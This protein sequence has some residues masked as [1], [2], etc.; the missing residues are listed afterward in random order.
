MANTLYPGQIDQLMKEAGTAVQPQQ[1]QDAPAGVAPAEAHEVVQQAG[2]DPSQLQKPEGMPQE[3]WDLVKGDMDMARRNT[4]GQT[5]KAGLQGGLDAASFGL[6]GPAEDAL[7]IT[8]AEGR[9]QNAEDHGV[10][11]AVGQAGGLLTSLFA[12]P[13]GVANIAEHAGVAGAATVGLGEAA[14]T[15]T[16]LARANAAFKAGKGTQEAVAAAQ[17][18]YSAVPNL[19]RIGSKATQLAIENVVIQAGDENAKMFMETTP[20]GKQAVADAALAH[21]GLAAALGGTLGAGGQAIGTGVKSLWDATKSEATGGVLKA[22]ADKLGGVPSAGTQ[23]RED[24]K[25]TA[26]IGADELSPSTNAMMSDNAAVRDTAAKMRDSPS[27]A[28]IAMKQALVEDGEM[29]SRKASEALGKSPEDL[30]NLSNVSENKT[31][32][33]AREMIDK[34]IRDQYAPLKTSYEK[35]S[36]Q[37]AEAPLQEDMRAYL[38]DSI[39]QT[40]QDG[41]SLNSP[42]GKLVQRVLTEIPGIT[43]LKQL[44]NKARGIAKETSGANNSELWDIGRRIK[45]A[46]NEVQEAALQMHVSNEAPELLEELKNTSGA[47]R[48]LKSDIT[49]INGRLGVKQAEVGPGTFLKNLKDMDPEDILRRLDPSHRADILTELGAKHPELATLIKDYHLS[50]VLRD[51]TY[52]NGKETL[53]NIPKLINKLSAKSMTP[54][55]RDAIVPEAAMDKLQALYSLQKR[56]PEKVGKSGTPEGLMGLV[57]QMTGSVVAFMT[58]MM[59]HGPITSGIM[60]GLT[61][62]L[63]S[64]A[65]DAVRYAML[66]FLGTDAPVNAAGFRAMAGVM[67]SALR[68]QELASDGVK[69]LFKPGVQVLPDVIMPNKHD[70]EK[71]QKHLDAALQNPSA[72]VQGSAGSPASHYMPDE[73]AAMG[74]TMNKVANYM[75]TLKPNVSPTG[76][77]DPARKPS[78]IEK[79]NYNRALEIAQQPLM[80]L[81]KMKNGSLNSKDVI[82]MKSMYPGM[83]NT[84]SQKIT[85]EIADMHSKGIPVPHKIQASMSLFMGQPMTGSLNPMNI[86]G[87]QP[88]PKGDPQQGPAQGAP[89]SMKSLSNMAGMYKTQGQSSEGRHSK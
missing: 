55:L 49:E 22:V 13:A 57:H 44:L 21:M 69:N 15:A 19:T 7:G 35:I 79:A 32:R 85:N 74:M 50:K 68:G 34:K 27:P 23:V 48:A 28:A 46:F 66:K 37:F 71:L 58:M 51:V 2:G 14:E 12:G 72:V 52:N 17:E 29:M 62:L 84:L 87:N 3:A 8:T 75:N 67:K 89:K 11:R 10:S 82:A 70:L 53:V 25:L 80:V 64:D 36:T 31:G 86:M 20:E 1:P 30:E 40:L 4:V 47:Y 76:P 38:Q 65:P 43:N 5:L 9:K 24:L 45:S 63:T 41:A 77:L 59:G 81:H 88:Q 16:A 26:G 6:A 39:A 78:A 56:I 33:E 73:T 54:E 60:G 83:Y 61:K 18:A 42:E